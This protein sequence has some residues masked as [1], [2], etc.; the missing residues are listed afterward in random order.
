MTQQRTICLKL[1]EENKWGKKFKQH[2]HNVNCVFPKFWDIKPTFLSILKPL[3][4]LLHLLQEDTLALGTVTILVP[5]QYH[6]FADN[7][8]CEHQTGTIRHHTKQMKRKKCWWCWNLIFK[9]RIFNW[10]HDECLVVNPQEGAVPRT[11]VFSDKG[12][13]LKRPDT[14]GMKNPPAVENCTNQIDYATSHMHNRIIWLWTWFRSCY[15]AGHRFKIA[16]MH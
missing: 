15:G 12:S 4:K 6:I 11:S 14:T 7:F 13:K 5:P 1:G 8:R 16:L 10:Q 9:M 3:Y 2:T